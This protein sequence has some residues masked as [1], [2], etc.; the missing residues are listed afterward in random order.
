MKVCSALV[1]SVLAAGFLGCGGEEGAATSA[2]GDP[3]TQTAAE[4]TQ[5]Q[6]DVDFP[7]PR[8]PAKRAPLERLV[9]KDLDLGKGPVARWGDEAIARYVGVYWE[10][11]KVFTTAVEPEP[12]GFELDPN[13]P[14]PGWM[15]GLHGMRVGG[16]RELRIPSNLLY[17]GGDGA[18][19]VTLVRIEPGPA[20]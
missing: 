11:G 18:F 20:K 15:K 5:A 9:V 14:A 1:V 16:W 8:L 7:R 19:V 17:E 3:R 10:T 6:Q 4:T 2:E 13:A 12:L